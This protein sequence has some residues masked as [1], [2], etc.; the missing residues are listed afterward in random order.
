M[1]KI[2][3]FILSLILITTSLPII[4]IA[5]TKDQ[6][7]LIDITEE[8]TIN[9]QALIKDNQLD[10]GIYFCEKG[11]PYF[12]TIANN[13]TYFS[14]MQNGFLQ[15]D[16][17]NNLI[18]KSD[19]TKIADFN[20]IG[21]H[22]IISVSQNQ[23]LFESKQLLTEKSNNYVVHEFNDT[24]DIAIFNTNVLTNYNEVL[25]YT[26]LIDIIG[27]IVKE[28]EISTTVE[29]NNS[30][31]ASENTSEFINSDNTTENNQD[32]S[33]TENSSPID[34]TDNEETSNSIASENDT[35]A[36]DANSE[37]TTDI[38]SDNDTP[39]DII[40]SGET[41]EDEEDNI[42]LPNA[43]FTEINSETLSE[44]IPGVLSQKVLES[45]SIYV[46][47]ALMGTMDFLLETWYNDE[48]VLDGN[49][50]KV[51]PSLILDSSNNTTLE[52]E[53]KYIFLGQDDDGNLLSAKLSDNINKTN[54]L[55]QLM[56]SNY[57]TII[58]SFDDL[59]AH[60]IAI[61]AEA[62]FHLLYC[63]DQLVIAI[64]TSLC[65]ENSYVAKNA[66]NNSIRSFLDTHK[67][68]KIQPF[69]IAVG[70]PIVYSGPG[71][72]GYAAVGSLNPFETYETIYK[73]LGFQYIEYTV[74]GTNTRKRGY[75][76]QYGGSS[77]TIPYS[78]GQGGNIKSGCT[79][80]SGPSSSYATVGSV[81]TGESVTLLT[82]TRI[83]SNIVY[84]YLEYYSSS[85]TK[86]GYVR[87]ENITINNN[88]GLGV[89]LNDI[90]VYD[91]FTVNIGSLYSNEYFVISGK[92]NL[93]YK[94]EYNTISGRKKGFVRKSDIT[95]INLDSVPN[96]ANSSALQA[97]PKATTNIYAGPSTKIYANIGSVYSTDTVGVL[98]VE[99]GYYY[100]QYSTSSGSKRGY[101]N[102][103]ALNQFSGANSV[104]STGIN[105]VAAYAD[106]PSS[107][108]TV[109]SCP[110]S[111]SATIGSISALEGITVFPSIRENGYTFVE[112][113]TASNTKRG[114][115]STSLLKKY[116]EGVKAQA[117]K[118]T[119]MFYTTDINLKIGSIYKQE[120]V[121]ILGKTSNYYYIEYNSPSGRKRGYANKDS[122]NPRSSSGIGTIPTTGETLTMNSAQNVYSGPSS[123]YASVGSVSKGEYTTLLKSTRGWYHIEYDTSSGHKQGYVPDSSAVTTVIPVYSEI[124]YRT[125]DHANQHKS[126]YKS[127]LG[128]D[129]IY[130][131]IG[132]LESD[133]VLFLN[134]AIHGHE[135]IYAGDGMAL[136]ELAFD[137]LNNLDN[138]Y[139]KILS[140]NWLIVVIPTFN[141]DGVIN[142]DDCELYSEC[143][144][145]GRHN[146][147]QMQYDKDN[148]TWHKY[149]DGLGHID[150][151]R[152]FPYDAKGS[153]DKR[154]N[155]I[156]DKRNYTGP[157]AM[158]AY[159]AAALN[160]LLQEY[161]T[162]SG[163]KYFIDIHGWYNQILVDSGTV[164][165][166][167][168][169]KA[170]Y[171]NGF[172]FASRN[173]AVSGCSYRTT[174]TLTN[175]IGYVAK[176]AYALGYT[177]CL[178]ELPA[179][180]KPQDFHGSDYEK[181]FINA[182]KDM[183]GI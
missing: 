76:D 10:P 77:G 36:D 149:N 108:C 46:S 5:Q 88:T 138:L 41:T 174:Y 103:N 161:K 152:C 23:T 172:N 150:L 25:I 68:T 126:N 102:K 62:Y 100:I 67:I 157:E 128:K 75:I 162:K 144:G 143:Q 160:E 11:R 54:G 124:N 49:E 112:Y 165:S 18:P 114:F 42:L 147:V 140:K 113:S 167:P 26:D 127:G 141:P 47:D 14:I 155:D 60:D 8:L 27:N 91:D 65:S 78:Y 63:G 175:G 85:G 158:M 156:S 82:Q 30:D 179:D 96:V 92:N 116:N 173:T 51:N 154:Y 105:T 133:N 182:V 118:D 110:N 163:K 115:I 178:F 15:W 97:T 38:T 13:K 12:Q 58:V 177:S 136:V 129:L 35:T 44:I 73:E 70:N 180:S 132:D 74:D 111:S 87:A 17:T 45:N 48:Y 134:F 28:S 142:G 64:N 135:D 89:T 170:L 94:I 146:A 122:L 39:S 95:T 66:F 104:K 119:D 50:I 22:L 183:I 21:H 53:V 86:R 153:F 29:E 176:Y 19:L 101:I 52:D 123:T 31:E 99:D 159:E 168:I 7:N 117:N 55:L 59:E 171:E 84:W 1:K 32:S 106:A 107:G 34:N 83:A 90:D 2:I 40:D 37:V 4:S 131:T 80:Y 120:Y 79:V 121:I 166:S 72:K 69:G 6:N 145:T 56:Y 137:T 98:G 3:T 16:F 71:K 43:S 33:T 20:D 164:S 125:Y 181:Y 169:G 57:S 109:Y 81:S 93:F 151:N 9:E 148:G 24:V 130:Y 61:D 139:S